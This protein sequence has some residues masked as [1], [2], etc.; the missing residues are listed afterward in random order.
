MLKIKTVTLLIISCFLG[1]LFIHLETTPQVMA[2]FTIPTRTP[3]PSETE[4]PPT[5]EPGDDPT[6]TPQPQPSEPAA[7]LP[8]ASATATVTA[9]TPVE[10]PIGG[11]LPTAEGC[12]YNPT[13][14]AANGP[15]TVRRG[16]GTDYKPAGTMLYLEVRPIVGRADSAP[17]WQIVMGDG[18]LRWVADSVVIVGGY[19]GF[20][21]IVPAPPLTDGST[22]TPSAEIWSPTPNPVCTP[23]P[24][25]PTPS[26]TPIP[27]NTPAPTSAEPASTATIPAGQ[28]EIDKGD[29]L[30]ETATANEPTATTT[31]QP[32]STAAGTTV[33]VLIPTPAPLPTA[34]ESSPIPWIPLAGVG[35]ILAGVVM[36]IIR[37]R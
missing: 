30:E 25:S 2:Q 29:I 36:F 33:A 12:S 34:P 11:Y 4:P 28:L 37:R 1:L 13:V 23:V 5:P 7:T 17:W 21:P 20:V 9:I 35:L 22:P 31:S 8:S 10:T 15:V 24:P 26:L 6:E 19:T 16:P 27:S 32:E 3:T 18:E 14:F